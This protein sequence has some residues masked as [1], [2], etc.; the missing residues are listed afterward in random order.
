MGWGFAF[1]FDDRKDIA[2]EIDCIRSKKSYHDRD[3]TIQEQ[4]RQRATLCVLVN[5]HNGGIDN[6]K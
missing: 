4:S 5:P 2:T 3:K 6:T 1:V